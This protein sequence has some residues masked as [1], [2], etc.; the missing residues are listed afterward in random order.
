MMSLYL[1]ISALVAGMIGL[2]WGADKFIAGSASLARSIGISSLV[3]G[4]TV[5]SIGTSAPEIIVSVNAALQGSGQLAVGN[6]LGS[7]I[8]NIG[9]VLGITLLITPIP[10]QKALLKQ[11][12]AI[13]FAV[14]GLAGICLYNGFLG[15]LESLL[16]IL[17]VIPLLILAAKYKK[18]LAESSETQITQSF[19]TK[20]ALISFFIGLISLLV[21]AE[22]TVWGA[23]AIA[24]T[25]GISELVIGLTIIAIGTSLPELAASIMSAIRGHHDIAVGN[26]IGSNLFNLLLVMGAAGAISPIALDSQVFS[27]DF[28]AMAALTLLMLIFMAAALRNK[29]DRPKLPKMVGLVLLAAYCLYYLV[30]WLSSTGN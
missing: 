6:A 22:L 14:T 3:V 7:N 10:I 1:P 29:E 24:L 28:M 30:L 18:S 12:G 21:C 20:D 16:L 9:L 17:L 5:V 25:M 23:K 13:L 19:S 26:I 4:L 27:R 2:I 11:E 8:A 15:R